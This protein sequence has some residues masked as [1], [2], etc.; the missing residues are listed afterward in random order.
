MELITCVITLL[1]GKYIV[2]ENTNMVVVDI[3]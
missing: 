2:K 3:P 1:I